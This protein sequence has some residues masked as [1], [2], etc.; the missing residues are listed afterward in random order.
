MSKLDEMVNYIIHTLENKFHIDIDPDSEHI[1]YA[2]SK[3]TGKKTTIALHDEKYPFSTEF[4]KDINKENGYSINIFYKDGETFM[5]N[6]APHLI[7][8]KQDKT[9]AAPQDLKK[10]SANYLRSGYQLTKE[11]QEAKISKEDKKFLF[12]YQPK[13]SRLSEAIRYFQ[14]KPIEIIR[15]YTTEKGKEFTK[16]IESTKYDFLHEVDLK[17][18]KLFSQN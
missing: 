3:K 17:K 16:E 10:Y 9:G 5:K 14:V 7:R 2:H 18:S 6:A 8:W 13:T 15:Q 4:I 1:L 12:Y 11:E